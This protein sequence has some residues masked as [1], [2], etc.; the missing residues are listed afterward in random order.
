M[1]NKC[2]VWIYIF[3]YRYIKC[4]QDVE[5]SIPWRYFGLFERITGYVDSTGDTVVPESVVKTEVTGYCRFPFQVGIIKVCTMFEHGSTFAIEERVTCIITSQR[6]SS[7]KQTGI[8]TVVTG[9]TEAQ[10]Q[11]QCRQPV[12]SVA[13]KSLIG[14]TPCQSG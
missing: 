10:T 8:D 14:N 2:S 5:F 3:M 6:I 9:S 11:F 4:R 1:M 13:H 12:V 7:G